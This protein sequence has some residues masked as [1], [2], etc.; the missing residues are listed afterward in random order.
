MEYHWL[1]L[2]IIIFLLL[3]S[4]F[5]SSSE[6]ALFA[7]DEIRLKKMKS[8]NARSRIK[9]LLKRTSLLLIT[10]LLGNTAANTAV[11]SLLSER[12]G[13]SHALL[14]IVI[15]TAILLFF[16]EISPKTIAILRIE[17]V[18][19]FNS[20]LL[21]PVFK[22]VKPLSVLIDS[23]VS[24]IINLISHIKKDENEIDS[25]HISALM[26]IVSREGIFEKDEK[27][28]I[29]SVLN[30][31]GREVWNIM[32]PR[33]KVISIEKD[34][35]VKDLI[36]LFKRTR[37]TKIPVYSGTDDNITGVVN[38]RAIFQFVHNPEKDKGMKVSDIQEQIYF[39]PETKKLSEMLEDFLKKKLGIAA[40]VDEYG[41]SLGIV[42][43]ADVL[44]EIV[45]EIMDES[46][47]MERK[48]I[49]TGKKRFLVSGDISLDDFN[50]FF[51]C[52]LSSS[53]Y[54][55]LAGYMIELAGDIPESGYTFDTEKYRII[56]KDRSE[57]HIEW[58]T[59]IEK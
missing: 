19:R 29:E 4:A 15:V 27:E 55:T 31:A 34:K 1:N 11:S 49:R 6:T 23:L 46:F 57:M 36:R 54:E 2:I 50:G 21:M 14:S 32:T 24:R 41:S 3:L 26:N 30:F 52:G 43:I 45:G 17:P 33:T 18:S 22:L 35:P 10:V 42:T 5:F 47:K 48:I 59:V 58:F 40:V 56:I 44:G 38:L 16:S 37:L 8:K 53:D 28:L 12:L 9:F 39:V 25:G 7:M 13:I 51:E 20:R